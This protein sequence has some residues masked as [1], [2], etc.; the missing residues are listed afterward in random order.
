MFN[1]IVTKGLLVRPE[2]SETL[3]VKNGRH[4]IRDSLYPQQ[5]VP[6]DA[7]ACETA[8]LQLVTGPNMVRVARPF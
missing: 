1:E 7:Y 6:N 5:F 3:A 8:N 4:P 2:F